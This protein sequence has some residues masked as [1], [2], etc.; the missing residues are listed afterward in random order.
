[1]DARNQL[2]PVPAVQNLHIDQLLRDASEVLHASE[3]LFAS[4]SDEQLTWKSNKKVWSILECF[5]H[6]YTVNGLYLPC[7]QEGLATARE[8]GLVSVE[9]FKPSWFGRLFIWGMQPDTKLKV[10]TLKLFKPKAGPQNLAVKQSFMDQQ[11]A[12]VE[13]IKQ[14]DPY[15]L[16]QIKI[17]SPASR[18]VKLSIGEALT[19]L[20][21]HERRHLLQAQNIQLNNEFPEFQI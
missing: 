16:N 15:N 18:L 8:K 2:L 7:I 20:V 21:A 19:G 3:A 4:L 5:D 10:K 17:T 13:L 9:P 12:F 11:A 6:L 14:A 1:M